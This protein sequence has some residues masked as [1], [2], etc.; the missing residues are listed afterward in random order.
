[1]ITRR[2][3][4]IDLRRAVRARKAEPRLRLI[5]E[6]TVSDLPALAVALLIGLTS[7][8]LLH[9][10]SKA[11]RGRLGRWAVRRAAGSSTAR[12]S[13]AGPGDGWP[14]SRSRHRPRR[15]GTWPVG[16]LPQQRLEER[17]IAAAAGGSPGGQDQ[18]G[19]AGH[20]QRQLGQAF[21]H[22]PAAAI[23]LDFQVFLRF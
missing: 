11:R 9:Q 14:P 4:S 6:L 10:A 20:R 1:M 16:A 17:L 7:E 21:D 23:G 18:M 2:S 8:S 15:F 22:G 12:P 3:S 5:I 13:P 19:R